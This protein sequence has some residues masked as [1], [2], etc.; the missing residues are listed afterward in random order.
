MTSHSDITI[1]DARKKKFS[2]AERS[3]REF[4]KE[5]EAVSSKK[6]KPVASPRNRWFPDVT[7]L[8]CHLG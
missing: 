2:D 6:R 5:I 3:L 4:K 7:S 1:G 8:E